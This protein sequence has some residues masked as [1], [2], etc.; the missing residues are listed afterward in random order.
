MR[1]ASFLSYLNETKIV[2]Y[3]RNQYAN[4]GVNILIKMLVYEN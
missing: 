2:S 3:Q 1:V 4:S